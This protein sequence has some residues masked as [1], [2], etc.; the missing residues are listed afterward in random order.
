MEFTYI[1]EICV[2]IFHEKNCLEILNKNIAKV[3]FFPTETAF[4]FDLW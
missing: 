4:T 2:V 3:D 1:D